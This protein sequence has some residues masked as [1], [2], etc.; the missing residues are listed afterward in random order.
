MNAWN[1]DKRFGA[2]YVDA[3]GDLAIDMALTLEGGITRANL[4]DWFA[5]WRLMLREFETEVARR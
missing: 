1:R 4:D 3:G 5:R 2:A